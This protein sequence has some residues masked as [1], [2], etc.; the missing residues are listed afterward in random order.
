MSGPGYEQCKRIERRKDLA[1]LRICFVT[2]GGALLGL[3]HVQQSLSLAGE[4]ASHAQIL[5]ITTS[6]AAVAFRISAAGFKVE[7]LADNDQV[8]ELLQA[9]NPQV[10]IFDKIDV[11]VGLASRIKRSLGARL[12]I[13][14]NLTDANSFADVAVT[15]DI[16][17]QFEN[18]KFVNEQTKTLTF[19]GPRYWVLRPEFGELH[20]RGKPAAVA[21]NRMLLIFGGSDPSNLTSAALEQLLRGSREIMLDVVLGGHFSHDSDVMDVLRRHED[22][23]HRVCI[24]RNVANIA[25]LM[26]A[27]DLVLASPG[28]SAFEALRVGTPIIVVPQDEL[29]FHTY[30]GFM[31]ILERTE[32]SSLGSMIE[33]QDFTFPRDPAITRMEIG[34]GL[35]ELKRAI[36]FP[37]PGD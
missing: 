9:E 26:F 5:F 33:L 13:F 19:F 4:L 8:F 1:R 35:E 11:S 23:A 24:H 22:T 16:G 3:G 30:R 17:S 27:A 10:V 31:K 7:R 12:V 36:L 18:V 6:D 20:R 34:E 2:D 15:A 28:L 21:V 32:L 14:T 37:P 29:Q 25:E